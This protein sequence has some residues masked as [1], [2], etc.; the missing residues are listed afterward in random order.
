MF[1]VTV[2]FEL[3]DG[4]AAAF[5]NLVRANAT[6]SLAQEPGCHR[7]DVCHDGARPNE[8]FLYELYD[9]AAAFAVHLKTPHF[10]AFDTAVAASV[11][12][13]TVATY[14]EVWS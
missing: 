2:K 4:T 7:F 11:T 1:A 5:L 14:G 12:A 10:K 6:D 9:D 3:V 8:V 13:K